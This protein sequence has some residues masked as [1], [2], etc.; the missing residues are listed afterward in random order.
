MKTVRDIKNAY[1]PDLFVK[2]VNNDP[3]HTERAKAKAE[4][5]HEQKEIDLNA[6]ICSLVNKE[7]KKATANVMECE[8]LTYTNNSKTCETFSYAAQ[9][10]C[11]AVVGSFV[12]TVA[13]MLAM[14]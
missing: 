5:H 2:M 9:W 11:L 7:V 10:A 6:M 1:D 12:M 8:H 13:A 4:R 3:S 14:V